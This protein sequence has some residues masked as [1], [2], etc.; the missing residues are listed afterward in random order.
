M[1]EL[2]NAARKTARTCGSASY[3]PA[4]A[5]TWNDALANAAERHAADMA[6]YN[7]FDHKSKDG[8]TLVN[9]VEAAGYTNWRSLAEN[10]AAG[11]TTPEEV[12]EGWLNSPGHCQNIMNPA[13]KEL[14]VGYVAG[15]SYRHYWVQDFGAR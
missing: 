3:G 5:L 2:T 11:Q 4:S 12:V 13:L 7:Y 9:R 1:L 8:R 10:I 14:G 15:G 6:A